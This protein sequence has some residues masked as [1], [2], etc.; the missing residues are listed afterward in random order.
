[1]KINLENRIIILAS[2]IVAGLLGWGILRPPQ[3]TSLF[4]MLYGGVRRFLQWPLFTIGKVPLT[5]LFLFKCMVFLIGLSF[6]SRLFRSFLSNRI[7]KH[8]SMDRVQQYGFV[9]RTG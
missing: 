8:T 3:F 5:P 9:R 6:F 7:L 4:C 1:M 2:V